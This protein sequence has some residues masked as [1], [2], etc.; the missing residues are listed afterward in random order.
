VGPARSEAELGLLSVLG[1]TTMVLMGPGSA[2]FGEVQKRAFALCHELPGK[3]RQFPITYGLCLYHWGR[4]EFEIAQPLARQLLDTANTLGS[5]DIAAAG[6]NPDEAVMAASNM[7]GMIAFHLGESQQARAHLQ[8]SVDLY[9]PERD[10]ALY[11]VYMMDFGVFGRFYL[12]LACFACGDA[13]VARQH[14]LDALSLAQKLNQPHSMGFSLL[15]N[16]NIAAMR[17]DHQMARQFA[18]Q[19]VGFSS[20][21]G[22][23][24]FIGIGRIVRGW[25][26][27]QLGQAAA[28][29]ED[30]EAGLAMWQMTG[31][32]NWQSWFTC[33]KADVLA[34]LG[35]QSQARAEVG[36]QLLRIEGNREMQFKAQ[37]LRQLAT[38]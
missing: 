13:D 2:P 22:F 32:E 16:M 6:G 1:P 8:R 12:A 37:L 3:P 21:F 31:F 28:G 19:C 10:A 35:R 17:N 34:L 20:Q 30:L 26:T 5:G 23:P 15:A 18:E 33:L 27:A 14:A 29:L 25:A 9:Q 36:A 7:N 24:E 38:L 4:A 11:P